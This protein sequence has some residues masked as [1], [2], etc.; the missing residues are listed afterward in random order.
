MPARIYKLY[1]Y[2]LKDKHTISCED[3]SGIYRITVRKNMN[4]ASMM[5]VVD[6]CVLRAKDELPV[7]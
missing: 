7:W 1:K 6:I 3:L 2:A 4:L 5:H